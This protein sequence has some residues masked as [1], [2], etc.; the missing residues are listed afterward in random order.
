MVADVSLSL[1]PSP[2]GS[3]DIS[4]RLVVSGWGEVIAV[5]VTEDDRVRTF[6]PENRDGARAP[7]V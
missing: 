3:K 4:V 2:V 5:V 6:I 1:G 7:L